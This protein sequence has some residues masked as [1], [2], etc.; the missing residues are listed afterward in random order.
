MVAACPD[1]N[2]C[3]PVGFNIFDNVIQEVASSTNVKCVDEHD[4]DVPLMLLDYGY[5][6]IGAGEAGLQSLEVQRIVD[7]TNLLGICTSGSNGYMAG[8]SGVCTFTGADVDGY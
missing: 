7:P 6:S 4:A 3:S 1:E 2:D 5:K 8:R